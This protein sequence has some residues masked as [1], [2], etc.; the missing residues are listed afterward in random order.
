MGADTFMLSLT[1]CPDGVDVPKFCSKLSYIIIIILLRG[2]VKTLQSPKIRT[3][4]LKIWPAT[5]DPCD[6][7]GLDM[8]NQGVKPGHA[9]LGHT[10]A[11]GKI[12]NDKW[13]C[14]C[15]IKIYQNKI[16]HMRFDPT[17]LS[18]HG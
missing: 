10:Y 6:T 7:N 16:L 15:V 12:Q 2:G 13:S 18:L 4:F 17:H 14:I 3:L 1:Q 8:K 5:T 11:Y 9:H